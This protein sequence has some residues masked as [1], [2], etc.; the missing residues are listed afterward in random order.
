MRGYFRENRKKVQE[1]AFRSRFLES[2][3]E[4]SGIFTI[5]DEK[6]KDD[7]NKLRSLTV[8]DIPVSDNSNYP[9]TFILNLE[10][11][12]L[13]G[14]PQKTKTVEKAFLVFGQNRL[15]VVLV[16]MKTELVLYDKRHRDAFFSIQ[17]KFTDTVNKVL[18][19]LTL[20]VFESENFDKFTIEFKGCV[21]YNKDVK[22]LQ[23]IEQERQL[24]NEPLYQVFQNR[25]RRLFLEND[26]TNK[27]KMDFFF[28]K[29]KSNPSNQ[30]ELSFNNF[31]TEERPFLVQKGITSTL[32]ILPK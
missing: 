6:V 24:V 30:M 31:F 1:A 17:K 5:V 21:A 28:Y 4:P 15:Y 14:T 18:L 29:N 19:F 12:P 2:F 10:E 25:Q 9:A 22:L 16:E 7:G 32:P 13:F 11:N 8:T 23:Q 20:Y 26:I 27:Q 3:T